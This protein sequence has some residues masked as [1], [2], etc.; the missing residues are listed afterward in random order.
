MASSNSQ[1][2]LLLSLFLLFHHLLSANASLHKTRHLSSALLRQ[3]PTTSHLNVTQPTR[4]FEVTKP[5]KLPRTKPC[6]HLIL[7]HDFGYTYGKSPVLA[8]YT[9]PSH[10]TPLQAS[11]IVLEFKATCKGRQFDRIF[12]VWLGGV[13]L[14]RGCTAEP[15]PSGILWSVEKDITKYHSLLVKNQRQ[16]LAVYLGNLID[17]TYT[18]VYHVNITIHFYTA[19]RN[20]NYHEHDSNNLAYGYSSNADLILPI[21]RNLPL[22]EGLWF[23]IKNSM[24]MEVKE[25]RIPRNA[26]RAVLEVFL[27][28][29]ENDEFW[30]TNL[31]SE[32]ISM[33][34]LADT[35][36]NGPFREVVISLDGEVVGAI[37]PFTVIYTGGIS[38]LLWTP[39]TGIGSF[40]L[41]SY[42]IEIT[43]FLGNI[44][45]GKIHR[46]GFSVTNALNLWLIDANLHLW[47]DSKSSTTE[48][49]LLK[50]NVMPLHVSLLSDFQG[51]NGKMLTNA[52]RSI[53]STGL[54]KSSYGEIT[55]H[56][57]QDFSYSNSILIRKDGNLQVFDQMIHFDDTV[58]TRMPSYFAYS[59]SSFKRFPLLLSIHQ[60]DR[61]NG[62]I[63]LMTDVKLGFYEERSENSGFDF[64]FSSLRNL[65]SGLVVLEVEDNFVVDALW[66]T[67]QTYKYHGSDL[68]YFRNISSSN[69]TVLYDKVENTCKKGPDSNSNV[70]ILHPSPSQARMSFLVPNVVNKKKG[71]LSY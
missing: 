52:S 5:I 47:L 50:H 8:N 29:H 38:P 16:T 30:Y 41:P 11:K 17:T 1:F 36:G 42:D 39:I 4:Y 9:P 23:Q 40:D 20:M 12:G 56:S 14:L 19:E 22:N 70:G 54:I 21:S 10:C 59:V 63:S 15:T 53:S 49:K 7:T 31:Q 6:S 46:F 60:L 3:S 44:L 51:L 66:N 35:P 34:K 55:T 37:W 61:K 58:Y 67:R 64:F 69:D 24:D 62:T 33:N 13:E 27:S 48:G 45:D 32:F 18:G 26:Y 43:P 28:F 71:V 65:Q 25:F 57:I 2:P 68:C